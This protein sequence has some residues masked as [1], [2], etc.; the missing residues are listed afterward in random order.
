MAESSESSV[1]SPGVIKLAAP[2]L[3]G[4]VFNWALYGVLCV[5]IYVYS[6]N[7]QID[8]R[9]VKFL[10]YFVFLLETV[11]TA[12]TGADIYH[13]FVAGF[14]NVERLQH[15]HFTPIDFPLFN[16][17]ISFIVQGYFCYRIWVL[18]SRSSWICLTIAVAAV[19]QFA[20]GIWA[21]IKPII[22]GKYVTPKAAIYLWA[23]PSALADIQIV[24][25][26][27][28]LLRRTSGNFSSFVLIR[29]VRLTV[30]TNALTATLAI[31][32]LVLYVTSPNELYYVYPID[33]LGKVCSNTLLVSLN[34][35]IYLRDHQSPE[36][37]DSACPPVLDRARV[38]T[39]TS[40]RFATPE[41]QPRAL[42]D[43]IDVF[44]RSIIPQSVD[45]DNSRG[46][47]TS[48]DWSLPQHCPEDLEWTVGTSLHPHG[49]KDEVYGL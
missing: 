28:L 43:D 23:I 25:A 41:P 24:V 19:T 42:K 5:Q 44:S 6:Y 40:L 27:T 1:A 30:E 21:S 15:S 10:A 20:G 16:T 13:W 2:L 36:Y 37:E 45:L 26:M 35:R 29:V 22:L 12:L 33:I 46:D 14:G 31:T 32:I 7:F 8:R 48:T 17:I 39:E 11:Q 34:N 38:I 4:P 9:S 3:F 47:D 49:R 18:N